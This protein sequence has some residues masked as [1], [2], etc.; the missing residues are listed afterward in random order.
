VEVGETLNE[1]GLVVGERLLPQLTAILEVLLADG[2]IVGLEE[3]VR[4]ESVAA[5]LRGRG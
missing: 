5:D 4:Q 2:G 1:S 3:V